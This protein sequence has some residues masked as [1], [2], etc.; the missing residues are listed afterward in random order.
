MNAGISETLQQQLTHYHITRFDEV[1]LRQELE[2]RAPTYTLVKL[3]EWPA[4]RWKCHYRIMMGS[5]M[6][7]AQSVSEAY[8]LALLAILQ[9]PDQQAPIE[10]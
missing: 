10:Q 6:H 8:A 5:G 1:S 2:Q 3:A 4:R 9:Q 7:D